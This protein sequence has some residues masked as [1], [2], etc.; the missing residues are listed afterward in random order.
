MQRLRRRRKRLVACLRKTAGLSISLD[1][2]LRS[3]QM[4]IHLDTPRKHSSF[5][6]SRGKSLI[7]QYSNWSDGCK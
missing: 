2:L 4:L 6:I 3:G 1:P 5:D 7:L